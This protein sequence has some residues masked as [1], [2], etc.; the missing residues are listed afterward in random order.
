MAITYDED[1]RQSRTITERKRRL[2]QLGPDFEI[3]RDILEARQNKKA[4]QDAG[5]DML[6]DA[7]KKK[8]KKGK[9]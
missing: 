9:A 6:L 7:V 3:E 8:K 5:M 4:R 2:A 1:G